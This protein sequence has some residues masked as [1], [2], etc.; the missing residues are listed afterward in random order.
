MGI[1]E[2]HTIPECDVTCIELVSVTR[3]VYIWPGEWEILRKY[4]TVDKEVRVDSLKDC[5][6]RV[7]FIATPGETLS[8]V[9]AT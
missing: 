2:Q 7:T 1:S 4:V 5:D 6:G 8:V 9:T 3:A